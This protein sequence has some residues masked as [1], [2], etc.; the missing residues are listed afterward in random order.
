[1]AILAMKCVKD[2]PATGTPVDALV[3]GI[4]TRQIAYVKG[5]QE[6]D[7]GFGDLFATTLAV[8]VSP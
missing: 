2:R 4:M 8:Q 3:Q 5:K 1:M 7:G 6:K